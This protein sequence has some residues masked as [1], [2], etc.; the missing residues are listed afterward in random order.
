VS[1]APTLCLAL[2]GTWQAAVLV[3][4][5]RRMRRQGD[6]AYRGGLGWT[7]TALLRR[8][9]RW[10]P[11]PLVAGPGLAL[12][13]TLPERMG[14]I[15]GAVGCAAILIWIGWETRFTRTR[16]TYLCLALLAG[17]TLLND[18][19]PWLPFLPATAAPLT[20]SFFAAQLYLV[21]GIRKL[22][23][24]QFLSGRV[25]LDNL[26]Y[27]I[28]QAAAGNREFLPL[29]RPHRL[30]AI[31][32]RRFLRIACRSGAIT[33]TIAEITLGFGALGWPPARPTLVL[34][35]ITHLAFLLVSPMRILPF[36]SAALG[37][38]T[39]ATE[40]PLLALP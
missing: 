1:I 9:R 19:G 13:T 31:L 6:Q 23:S 7:D 24:R 40:H 10:Y 14:Q 12:A 35:V 38:L 29:A 22:R 21:A 2:A 11:V 39:L 4:D 15:A 32:D 26:V 8:R 28:V 30:A 27:S 5:D 3:G 18:L 36:T 16:F 33:A 37:L 20:A 34:A 17:T 25:L